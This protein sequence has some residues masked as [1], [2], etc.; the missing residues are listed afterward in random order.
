MAP[1]VSVVIT[2]LNRPG[3][4]RAACESVLRQEMEDLE[5]IICDDASDE[6]AAREAAAEIADA[7]HRV[8]VIQ[9]DR[10]L[11]QYQTVIKAT[12]ELQGRYFAILNDD[13]LWEPGFLSTLVPPLESD[14][15]LV[16]SFCDH[17]IMDDQGV[18]NPKLS[19]IS[20]RQCCRDDLHPGKHLNGSYLAFGL[21]AFPT[22]V[23]SV[24]RTSAVD[25]E[26]YSRASM[27]V[28][29]FYDLWLQCCVLGGASAVW[30]EPHRLSRY[31]VHS[32]Q[33][34]G[35]PN[36]ALAR[37]K[38]WIWEEALDAGDMTAVEQ[39]ILRQL[40]RTHHALGMNYLRRGQLLTARSYLWRACSH[41]PRARSVLG[42]LLTA[43][44][45]PVAF[46]RRR[47]IHTD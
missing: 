38:A 33:L 45:R 25:W 7:D 42:L 23:A 2:S 4:L 40:S 46:A 19:D 32:G 34:S 20:T 11:G 5:V 36:I 12:R 18:V 21:S 6:H 31:R 10:R 16:A 43:D 13:D 29:G 35:K 44:S 1:A 39:E 14:D 9:N 28:T 30:Y 15:T 8:S 26:R 41:A 27:D 47:L 3:Y 37:A 24:F 22:V 17:F